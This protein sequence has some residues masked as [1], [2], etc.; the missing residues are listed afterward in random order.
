MFFDAFLFIFLYSFFQ[1]TRP[2]KS[3]FPT[4]FSLGAWKCKYLDN[5]LHKIHI[6]KYITIKEFT[7]VIR[8]NTLKIN[9]IYKKKLETNENK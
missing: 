5:L 3:N 1:L 7:D 9:I 4:T 8:K 2:A 6:N